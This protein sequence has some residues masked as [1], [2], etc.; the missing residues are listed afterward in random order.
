ME[1]QIKIGAEGK[2]KHADA[3]KACQLGGRWRV[4]QR[5]LKR[6]ALLKEEP[7]G[8]RDGSH[9]RHSR[10]GAVGGQAASHE[11]PRERWDEEGRESQADAKG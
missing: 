1:R 2:A 11:W 9:Q 6:L 10:G 3:G 4:T 8:H 7:D 5:E